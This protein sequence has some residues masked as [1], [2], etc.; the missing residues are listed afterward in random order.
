MA[1]RAV[2]GTM[3]FDKAR[4]KRF[5]RN[6]A[7]TSC[8]GFTIVEMMIAISILAVVLLGAAQM[9]ASAIR[10]NAHGRDL[11]SAI[12]CAQSAMERITALPFNQVLAEN[13]PVV[14][15][16]R[17]PI[18]PY[19]RTQVTITPAGGVTN[20]QVTVFWRGAMSRSYTINSTV[21][22]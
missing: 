16:G 3:K 13:F 21:S 19:Y 9:Q 5:L 11:T 22:P 14:D 7:W 20:V 4:G 18:Y 6:K 15:Y 12:S 10:S 8:R 1:Q 17:D 2:G